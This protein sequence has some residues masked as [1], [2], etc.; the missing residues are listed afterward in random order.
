MSFQPAPDP[1]P[2]PYGPEGTGDAVRHRFPGCGSTLRAS[3]QVNDFALETFV[4]EHELGGPR[5]G[6]RVYAVRLSDPRRVVTLLKDDRVRDPELA[7][8]WAL[9]NEAKA[10]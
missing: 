6:Q 2:D 1:I 9:Y 10:G 5:A 4:F 8:R 3:W 7:V